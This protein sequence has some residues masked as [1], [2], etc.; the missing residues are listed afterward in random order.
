[1][2]SFFQSEVAEEPPSIQ[3][4]LRLDSWRQE[5]LAGLK[6]FHDWATL[7]CPR[8]PKGH[9]KIDEKSLSGGQSACRSRFC[10]FLYCI[11]CTFSQFSCFGRNFLVF[12]ICFMTFSTMQTSR[13]TVIYDG[14]ST[15]SLFDF[16]RTSFPKKLKKYPKI[17]SK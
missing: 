6:F 16:F 1:M 10:S 2:R 14:L 9:P 5:G 7:G 15:F 17:R 8:G 11:S 12:L 4:L 13:N 3:N